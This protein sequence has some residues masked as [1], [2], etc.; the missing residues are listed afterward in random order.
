MLA[1]LPYF[2]LQIRQE[3]AAALNK[4]K[5]DETPEEMHEKQPKFM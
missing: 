3:V 5:Q 1:L 4:R 2:C